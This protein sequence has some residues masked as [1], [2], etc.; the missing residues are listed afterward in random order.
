MVYSDSVF[1]GYR[2]F[3]KSN[4]KPLF[5][6]GF[7]MS[8]TSYSYGDL[9]LSSPSMSATGTVNATFTLTNT[10]SM[11]GFEVAQLYVSPAKPAVA[12]PLKELKGFVKVYLNAGESK[13]VSI[14]IDAR[15]L[16]YFAPGKTSWIVDAGSYAIRVGPSSATLPLV[17]NLTAPALTLPT[18]TSNP[19]PQPMRDSVQV[20]ADQAY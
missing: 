7:G 15:S 19:L 20:S 9:Q 3:D 1:M 2:G 17:K 11:A 16:S 5:P 6:F 8:Y 13:R 4:V 14:P 18:N 10:G 12:R